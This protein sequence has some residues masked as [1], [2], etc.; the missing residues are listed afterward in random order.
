[1]FPGKIRNNLI[2]EPNTSKSSWLT[3]AVYGLNAPLNISDLALTSPE[4]F[5]PTGL[6]GPI[7]IIS[8]SEFLYLLGSRSAPGHIA[9]TDS[10]VINAGRLINLSTRNSHSSLGTEIMGLS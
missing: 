8:H 3:V 9:F 7:K 6:S 1:M 4:I 5:V 2:L 10:F